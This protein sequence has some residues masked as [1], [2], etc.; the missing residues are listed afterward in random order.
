[1]RAIEFLD[2]LLEKLPAWAEQMRNRVVRGPACRG[3]RSLQA[4]L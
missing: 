2:E 3:D 4:S 1:M